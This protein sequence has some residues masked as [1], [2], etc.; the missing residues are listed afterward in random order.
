MI[1]LP[2]KN[3]FSVIIKLKLSTSKNNIGFENQP[4]NNNRTREM[5]KYVF[6]KLKVFFPGGWKVAVLAL[7]S[8]AKKGPGQNQ[9]TYVSSRQTQASLTQVSKTMFR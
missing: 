2:T 6:K 3:N 4:T 1:E 5:S 8:V 9:T 7:H